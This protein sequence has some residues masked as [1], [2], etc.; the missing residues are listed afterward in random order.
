MPTK[1][2]NKRNWSPNREHLA[3][4]AGFID[5]EGS[6]YLQK[7]RAQ[8][9]GHSESNRPRFEISQIDKGVLKHLQKV[10]PFGAKIWGPYDNKNYPGSGAK[11]MFVYSVSG[12]ENVQALLAL[13]WEWLGSVKRQQAVRVLKEC[14][15]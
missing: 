2:R 1:L 15:E 12:F 5:G 7:A 3:W 4:A 10:L 13:V 14:V 11:P 8:G 6:F 9:T